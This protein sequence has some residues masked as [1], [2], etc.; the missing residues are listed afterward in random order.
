MHKDLVDQIE[1][2][3]GS[4]RED[5][6]ILDDLSMQYLNRESLLTAFSSLLTRLATDVEQHLLPTVETK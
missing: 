2:V 1:K 5:A 4:M 3:V 6:H